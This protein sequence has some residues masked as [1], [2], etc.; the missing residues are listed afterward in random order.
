MRPPAFTLIELLVVVGI[1]AILAALMVP[2]LLSARKTVRNKQALKEIMDIK[3]AV[4]QYYIERN[5]YPPDTANWQ[6]LGDL[7]DAR[8]IHRYLGRAIEDAKGRRFGPYLNVKID[9]VRDIQ[10]GVGIYMDPWDNDY[11]MDAV[12]TRIVNKTPMGVGA[13]Y[14]EDT[15]VPKDQRTL[16]C[17]IVSFGPDRE[18]S[19]YY[20]PFDPDL[21]RPTVAKMVADD[22]RSW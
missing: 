13:P 10:D 11:H 18:A 16:G 17:K 4:T 12:H 1:I 5:E 7:Y 14:R 15:G 6:D 21:S 20:Y 19:L 3:G 8:S 22:I 9:N 2:V